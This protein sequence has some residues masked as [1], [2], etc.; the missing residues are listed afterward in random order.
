MKKMFVTMA[1]A[2]MAL[3]G[4]TSC[5]KTA[6]E[7]AAED[8][9]AALKAKI[10]NC[11]NPDSLKIYV[12]QAQAYAQKLEAEG[13]G[14][15]AEAYLNEVAPVIEKKDTTVASYFRQLTT[16]AKDEV[17]EAKEAA[18]SVANAAKD[19][20]NA[21]KDSVASKGAAAVQG[22][23]DAASNAG[24]AVKKAGSDAVQGAKDAASNAAQKG[25]DEVN[26]LL[27]K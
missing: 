23:K 19:K 12:E 1:I 6:G 3:V 5:G 16:K 20:V 2:A 21:A 11:T 7:K 4:I 13:K 8:E 18:D 25:A 24:A 27:N 26:K 17:K 22:V 15:D 9:G 10:E 14:G